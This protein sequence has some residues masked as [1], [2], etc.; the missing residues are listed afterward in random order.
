MPQQSMNTNPTDWR[1]KLEELLEDPRTGLKESSDTNKTRTGI[2]AL[3][4]EVESS[5]IERTIKS[6][7]GFTEHEQGCIRSQFSAG[8][9]TKD[10]GYRQK[11]AGK[12]YQAKPI[13]ETPTCDCGLDAIYAHLQPKEEK[14]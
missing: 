1:E 12:W 2:Y 3:V 4:E 14:I 7:D 11:F 9:R 8:E 5:A 6:F 10:G 13:D